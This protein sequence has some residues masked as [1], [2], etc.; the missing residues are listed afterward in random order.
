MIIIIII[1]NLVV[2]H[3]H[4]LYVVNAS[5]RPHK[6]TTQIKVILLSTFHH[7]KVSDDYFSNTFALFSH[8]HTISY[9]SCSRQS[10]T[11]SSSSS[12]FF[13]CSQL[14]IFYASTIFILIFW[15]KKRIRAYLV[16]HFWFNH[17]TVYG[18]NVYV[19]T[20]STYLPSPI[21]ITYYVYNYTRV[22]Y[23]FWRRL[24]IIFISIT[25][26]FLLFSFTCYIHRCKQ[27]IHNIQ[28]RN[29]LVV[30]ERK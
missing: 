4:S 2:T 19:L 20:C 29:V 18:T 6:G 24:I 27:V 14:H 7:Q 5:W 11:S 9:K 1:Y 10:H 25:F 21:Y 16:R 22:C 12:S 30:V 15:K 17:Y 23:F 13:S 8:F 28:C 3:R 26:F